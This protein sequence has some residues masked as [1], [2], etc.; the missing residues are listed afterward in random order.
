MHD[1]KRAIGYAY[2]RCLSTKELIDRVIGFDKGN[3]LSIYV[4]RLY[5]IELTDSD[6]K[7]L[8][9]AMG[10]LAR[11]SE[12]FP[13]R[14]K[15]IVDR[16]LLRLLR[17]LP[18]QLAV[19]FAIPYLDHRRKS[20]RQWAYYA[21]RVVPID[22]MLAAKLEKVYHETKDIEAL[23]ILVLNPDQVRK[24]GIDF[25]LRTFTDSYWRARVFEAA[26]IS[27]RPTALRLAGRYPIEF[28]HA[29]GRVE[30]PALIKPLKVLFKSNS[31][32]SEFLSI[33]AYALGKL[34]AIN[35]I[36]MLE[37]YISTMFRE[38][39]GT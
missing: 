12:N 16:A 24:I 14:L 5:E 35:E 30:D 39:E 3:Q 4:Y 25:L 28:T 36:R 8:A 23:K 11:R 19:Q 32:S 18:S 1:I 22:S 34:K 17:L 15:T 38:G 33:Y 31:R 26:L 21:M 7:K 13:S 9:D 2:V 37:E 27:D 29:V 10:K 20:R 6:L